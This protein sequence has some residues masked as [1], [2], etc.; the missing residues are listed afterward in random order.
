MMLLSSASAPAMLLPQDGQDLH[1]RRRPGEEAIAAEPGPAP[2]PAVSAGPANV[3][4]FCPGPLSG[5]IGQWTPKRPAQTGNRAT[6]SRLPAPSRRPRGW[7]TPA[8]WNLLYPTRLAFEGVAWLALLTAALAAAYSWRD[9]TP[10]W[11]L[12]LGFA[13]LWILGAL[14]T[15]FLHKSFD[16][17]GY[18]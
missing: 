16:R 7:L 11:G 18:T 13:L 14:S 2:R 6:C 10:A 1:A 9:N 4:L 8:A 17:S 12:V 15:Y 3:A 5:T